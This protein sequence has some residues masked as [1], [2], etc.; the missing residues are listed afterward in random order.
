MQKFRVKEQLWKLSFTHGFP[1]SLWWF[2][3]NSL[4]SPSKKVTPVCLMKLLLRP[5]SWRLSMGFSVGNVSSYSEKELWALLSAFSETDL[6]RYVSSLLTTG[7]SEV[8]GS[9]GGSSPPCGP[10]G[11]LSSSSDSE[12]SPDLWVLCSSD[13]SPTTGRKLPKIWI[14]SNTD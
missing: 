5:L 9:C 1:H 14:R 3:R 12:R 11:T 10:T 6:G 2:A 4:L 8:V 13:L 7:A